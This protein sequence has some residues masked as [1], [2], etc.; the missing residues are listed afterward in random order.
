MLAFLWL[1]VIME[2]MK[3]SFLLFSWVY[4]FRVSLVRRGQRSC[5]LRST[6]LIFELYP[7]ILHTSLP[8]HN[9]NFTLPPPACVTSPLLAR[10]GVSPLSFYSSLV[11]CLSLPLA[12]LKPFVKPRASERVPSPHALRSA[13]LYTYRYPLGRGMAAVAVLAA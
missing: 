7:Y 6:C 8:Y 1:R 5:Q 9:R 3:Q 2:P 12:Q 4:I 10:V 13:K 11:F